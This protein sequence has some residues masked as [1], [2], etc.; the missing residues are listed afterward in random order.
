MHRLRFFSQT[1]R[2]SFTRILMMAHIS[3]GSYPRIRNGACARCRSKNKRFGVFHAGI[4]VE[5]GFF[6]T[7][8]LH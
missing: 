6:S 3:F 1:E 4:S 8:P 5:N 7:L 2:T